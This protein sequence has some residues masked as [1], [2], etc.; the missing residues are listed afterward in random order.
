[1][2]RPLVRLTGPSFQV[3]SWSGCK[4]SADPVALKPLVELL[5]P[6]GEWTM[7]GVEELSENQCWEL[8][9]TTEVGRL[10]VIVADHPEVF[11][12]NYAVDQGTVLFRSAEGTKVTSALSDAPVAFEA[13]GYDSETGLVWS[14]V[15]KGQATTFQGIEEAA[16]SFNVEVRPWQGG[17]KER[18]IC[19]RPDEVTGRRFPKVEKAD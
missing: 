15:L 8:L 13:D 3:D 6:A 1:M 10:A 2:A 11:P 12:V 9:R 17:K 19:I 4:Q 16:D 14:V 18:F 5:S 7:S